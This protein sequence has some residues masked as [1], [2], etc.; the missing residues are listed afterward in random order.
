[1]PH[2]S[3][4]NRRRDRRTDRPIGGRVNERTGQRGSIER[5]GG[6]RFGYASLVFVVVVI[7]V[8]VVFVVVVIVAVVVV[9][10]VV[11]F[12]V[13]VVVVVL[14]YDTTPA[15]QRAEDRTQYRSKYV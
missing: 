4:C 14:L 3:K 12:V 1:M 10:V 5:T 8:V 7:V 11:V 2:A 6:R 15:A 9:V 13:F